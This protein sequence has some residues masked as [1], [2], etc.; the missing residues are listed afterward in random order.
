MVM[1]GDRGGS[2]AVRPNDRGGSMIGSPTG[3]A[4]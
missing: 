2:L 3:E 1:H 4:R